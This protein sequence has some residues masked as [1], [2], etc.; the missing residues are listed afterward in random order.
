MIFNMLVGFPCRA[1]RIHEPARDRL[2]WRNVCGCEPSARD[3]FGFQ[4]REALSSALDP[5]H[6][7]VAKTASQE[8]ERA[9]IIKQCLANA[10]GRAPGFPSV[11]ICALHELGNVDH[12][13]CMGDASPIRQG[14]TSPLP[15]RETR[16][17]RVGMTLQSR[18]ISRLDQIGKTARGASL[19]AGLGAT[20]IKDI[21]RGKSVAPK[22]DTIIKLAVAL[23][24]TPEWLLESRG[25][26]DVYRCPVVGLIGAGAMIHGHDEEAELE[27]IEV[28]PGAKDVAAA[29]I[30]KGNSQLPVFRDGDVVFFGEPVPDASKM[31]GVECMCTLDCGKQYVKT[32]LPGTKSD[33]FTLASHNEL[34]LI[35]AVLTAVSP[36]LWVR[37]A[38]P[39]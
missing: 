17:E 25:G 2:T 27:F 15:T 38:I 32:L 5:A 29:A 36:V 8:I 39:S 3:L 23:Q 22:T 16:R 18:I 4:I 20:F 10:A 30:V 24:T 34:P 12:V 33:R 21:L 14:D 19:D 35:D 6:L 1:R 11:S 9:D 37:R 13:R 26:A 31:L 28:P 7:N